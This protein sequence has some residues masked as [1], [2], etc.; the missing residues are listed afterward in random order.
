[1]TPDVLRDILDYERQVLELFLTVA[2][3]FGGF[4]IA[5]MIALR[6]EE[7]RDRLHTL[8]F[9]A[10][11]LA[12]TAF[13]FATALDSVWLPVSRLVRLKT[14]PQ[15]QAVLTVGD[16]IAWAVSIGTVSLLIAVGTFGFA[17]SRRIGWTVLGIAIAAGIVFFACVVALIR[18]TAI[19]G[20]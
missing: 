13:I 3:I 8:S 6:A 12:A 20:T 10:L 18:A 5:G 14:A 7:R 9:L 17:R 11:A 16:V 4:A 19:K 15:L 2:S 1:M